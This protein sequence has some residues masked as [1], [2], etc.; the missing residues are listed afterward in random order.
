MQ[1]RTSPKKKALQIA[2][3]LREES[4]DY[5]YLRT[6]FMHLRQILEVTVSSKPKKLP[7]V[8]TEY[9]IQKY[10]ESVWRSQ[11]IQDVIIIKVLLYTGIRVSELIRLKKSDVDTI[12]CQIRVIAGKGKKDRI[13][14]F[15]K[16]F[17]ETLAIYTANTAENA[18]SYLF[19][20]SWKKPYSDRGIRR[21][22]E[23]YSQIS[24]MEKNISPHK[25]RHFLFTW[26]K[27]QGINDALIQPYSGHETRKS[28]EVYSKLSL[29][30][31][32]EAYEKNI[33][34]FP[35]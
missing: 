19:E 16:S 15:P 29:T 7:Y 12:G 3:Y 20:S 30:E 22:L 9:E 18:T 11:N 2:R 8:P 24:G 26:L 6:L 25:L 13:V 14:P 21:I 33:K 4:P 23:K 5:G 32:Q 17:R 35:V 10:Y 34:G 1:K 27:K 28:L 31:A